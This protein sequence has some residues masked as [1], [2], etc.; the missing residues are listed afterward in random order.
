VLILCSCSKDAALKEG[1]G[2]SPLNL[3]NTWEY[4]D[5][6]SIV[7]DS[8]KTLD[9]KEYFRFISFGTSRIDTTYYREEDH[10]IFQKRINKSEYFRFDLNANV[11]DSWNYEEISYKS[12]LM[13]GFLRD[14]NANVETDNFKF[15]NCYE[16][17]FDHPLVADEEHSIFLAKDI[18]IVH[19]IA[20]WSLNPARTLKRVRIEG[21]E[22]VFE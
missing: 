22:V 15:K 18:G 13:L 10:K 17:Y 4:I 16:F 19:R 3:G 21:K 5:G 7:T 20:V 11:N 6:T 2:Y 8:M 14:K 1:Q 12:R 9:G